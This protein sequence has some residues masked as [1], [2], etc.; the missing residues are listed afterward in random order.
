M[1]NKII[2]LGFRPV[3]PTEGWWPGE[4]FQ[5]KKRTY[6][7]VLHLG[8]VAIYKSQFFM[9]DG[10]VWREGLVFEGIPNNEN[11]LEIIY[12]AVKANL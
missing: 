11:E 10:W 2:E 7:L 8:Y 3:E 4:V 5:N 12:N 6:H 1:E 9:P